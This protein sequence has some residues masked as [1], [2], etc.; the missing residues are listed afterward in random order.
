MLQHNMQQL[1]EEGPVHTNQFSRLALYNV[2]IGLSFW[3]P[4]L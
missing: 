3:L 1:V 2:V 4:T